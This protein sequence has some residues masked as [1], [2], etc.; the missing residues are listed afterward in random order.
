V[1]GAEREAI[2]SVPPNAQ[3]QKNPL[4]F[5][6]HGHGGT[7]FN[8]ALKFACESYWP[9]AIVVYPQGLRTPGGIV[10]AEGRYPG[11]QMNIGEMGDRD[12]H[13]FDALLDYLK[14]RYPIDEGRV[15]VVGHSNGGLFSYE[16]W[17]ARPDA[18][19]GIGSIA[20]I[21]PTKVDRSTLPPK[22]VFHVAGK[23]DPLVRYEWQLETME[24][25]RNLNRCEG[26]WDEGTGKTALYK[27]T[28][29]TPLATYLHDGGHEVPEGVVSQIVE[30]FEAIDD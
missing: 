12:I 2:A 21:I 6:F 14:G 16:L 30:F 10:D 27:S 15:Y 13:F 26:P 29:G 3:A 19:A 28:V 7:M 17:A 24:F 20:A 9:E 5:A 23:S 8:A 25:I 11:W 18:I 22:P 1:D 4:I